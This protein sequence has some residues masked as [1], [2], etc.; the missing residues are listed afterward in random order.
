VRECELECTAS[1]EGFCV[2]GDELSGQNNMKLISLRQKVGFD[3]NFKEYCIQ[4]TEFVS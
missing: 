1:M 2:D 4:P 3:K